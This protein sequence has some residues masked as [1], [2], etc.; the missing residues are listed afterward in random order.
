MDEKRKS[1]NLLLPEIVVIM[2]K[3]SRFH[4]NMY[5][6]I[7]IIICFAYHLTAILKISFISLHKHDFI[8]SYRD[9]LHLFK[10]F[11]NIIVVIIPLSLFSFLFDWGKHFGS[12]RSSIFFIFFLVDGR[13]RL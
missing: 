3:L 9:Y 1:L 12:R 6:F 7:Y 2:E 5:Q 13:D 8:I 4:E 10:D 11:E